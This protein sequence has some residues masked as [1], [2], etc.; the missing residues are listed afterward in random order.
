MPRVIR[1]GHVQGSWIGVTFPSSSWANVLTIFRVSLTLM[2]RFSEF[3]VE[4]TIIL[5]SSMLTIFRISIVLTILRVSSVLMILQVFSVLTIIRV[6]SVLTNLCF[7][8]FVIL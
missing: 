3:S 8:L 5:V 7:C 2:L 1:R 6:P 4:L